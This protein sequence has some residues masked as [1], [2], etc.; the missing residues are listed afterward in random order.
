MADAYEAIIDKTIDVLQKCKNLSYVK[1]WYKMNGFVPNTLPTISAGL[2]D[3]QYEEYTQALDK[4]SAKMNIFATLNNKV[5]AGNERRKDE[6]R[7]EYGERCIRQMA[8]SIRNCLIQN[9]YLEG[10]VDSSF[11]PKIEYVTAEGHEDLH[12]AVISFYV[13]FFVPRKEED[14]APKI[15]TINIEME[16]EGGL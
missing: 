4:C 13:D 5:L 2:E 14:P 11:P 12:V 7:L 10:A 6:Q 16:M 9:Y 1:M 15:E 8:H 3:E